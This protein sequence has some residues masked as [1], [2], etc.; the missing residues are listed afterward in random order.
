VWLI[1]NFIKVTWVKIP[2]QLLF[3]WYYFL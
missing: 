3:V 2:V 1:L